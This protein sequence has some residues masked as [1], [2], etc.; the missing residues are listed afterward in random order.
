MEKSEVKKLINDIPVVDSYNKFFKINK[1]WSKDKK[2][3][4]EDQFG[5]KYLVRIS[6]IEDLDIKKKEFMAM[7]KAYKLGI[8]MSQPIEFGICNNGKNVY[9]LLSWITGKPLDEVINTMNE[10]EQFNSGIKAGRILKKFHSIPAPDYQEDW[11]Q[12]MQKK[13]NNHFKRYKKCDIK[14][15]NDNY[16]INY[17]KENMHLL[18]NRPQ[19][20]HHGDF[21]V[22]N[23]ILT[24]DNNIGVIDF[25]RCD[26][27]DPYEEFY[28]MIFFSRELSIPFSN[29]QIQGYFTDGIPDDFF[30]LL[31][32]Y[33]ADVTFP[34]VVWAIPFGEDDTKKMLK[35]TEMIFSDYENF[36]RVIPKWFSKKRV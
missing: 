17:I 3:Y 2:F 11:E 4:I 33:V 23:L 21:H 34:S 28:K 29:G 14:V 9:S 30:K 32:L 22:G 20:F 13:F 36:N 6:K 15:P 24:L 19:T 8:N 7:K 16:A 26:Y 10:E 12:R 25:N 35:R 1:G 5:K 27:G 18:K 31:A